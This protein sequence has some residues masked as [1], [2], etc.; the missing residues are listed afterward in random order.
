MSRDAAIHV[1]KVTEEL[2][3]DRRFQPYPKYRA[4][5]V[6]WLGEIPEHWQIPPLYAAYSV[7]LG[8][9]LDAKRI[10]KEH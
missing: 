4:S 2:A 6:E 10:T 8:K 1:E 3:P 7:E 9:M 5:G